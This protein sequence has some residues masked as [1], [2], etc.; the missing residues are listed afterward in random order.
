MTKK[1]F[2]SSK[3]PIAKSIYGKHPLSFLKKS[4]QKR[5]TEKEPFYKKAFTEK[6]NG[7][8]RKYLIKY[9]II[10]KRKQLFDYT[11]EEIDSLSV[12]EYKDLIRLKQIFN[13]MSNSIKTNKSAVELIKE[14]RR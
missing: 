12:R 2:S 10:W 5:C 6:S 11:Q 7:Y 14:V 8:S 9:L 1:D 4:S 3:N 13:S